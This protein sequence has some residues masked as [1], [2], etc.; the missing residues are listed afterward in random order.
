[1]V[2]L[3]FDVSDVNLDDAAKVFA[4]PPPPGMYKAKVRECKLGDKLDDNGKAVPG[5][6]RLEIV[7]ETDDE[8]HKGGWVYEYIQTKRD[9]HE[10]VRRRLTAFLLATG[11]I[12]GGKA[13]GNFDPAK[14]VGKQVIIRVRAGENLSG[15]YKAEPAG[16]WA[17][18]N[19]A[20]TKEMLG[21]SAGEARKTAKASAEYDPVKGGP[22]DTP[23][24][25]VAEANGDETTAE[26]G[27]LDLR[28]TAALADTGDEDAA[29]ML[30]EWFEAE[31]QDEEYDPNNYALWVEWVEALVEND[32]IELPAAEEA[33]ESE[34]A[35]DARPYSE[36][37]NEELKAEL[38]NRG[39]KTTGTRTQ[40]VKRLEETEEPF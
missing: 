15:D 9:A 12:K 5:T 21:V 26:E 13:S 23:E 34:S 8:A 38:A 18:N 28:A 31:I 27:E 25:T 11:N 2:T 6:Q 10:V 20:I 40:L 35:E 37:S 17:A 1:M 29:T 30:Q 22:F 32:F 4:P 3:A 33:E 39:Q 36:W 16:V 24:P 19:P 7:Y 14:Q